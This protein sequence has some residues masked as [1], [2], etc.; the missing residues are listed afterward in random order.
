MPKNW[1]SWEHWHFSQK[2]WSTISWWCAFQSA[3]H[4]ID[5]QPP[6][7][8]RFFQDS[9][10]QLWVHEKSRW[11]MSD[12]FGT[13]GAW[14]TTLDRLNLPM[15]LMRLHLWKKPFAAEICGQRKKMMIVWWPKKRKRNS[16]RQTFQKIKLWL[17]KWKHV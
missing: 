15:T 1:P 7:V 9:R 4:R 8:S 5:T 10:R 16:N 6:S 11:M 3:M 14:E 12:N 17:I 2:C 13:L